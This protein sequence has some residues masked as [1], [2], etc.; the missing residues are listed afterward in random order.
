M[1]SEPAPPAIESSCAGAPTRMAA[2]ARV[3]HLPR[4]NC[5]SLQVKESARQ[6]PG[7]LGAPEQERLEPNHVLQPTAG[8]FASVVESGRRYVPAAVEHKR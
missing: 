4:E 2:P 6:P 7:S 5:G 8:P 3:E 1:R